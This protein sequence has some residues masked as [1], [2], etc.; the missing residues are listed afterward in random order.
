MQRNQS[1]SDTYLGILRLAGPLILTMSSQMLMQFVDALFL[2]WYSADAV[3]A[4]I[5]AGMAGWLVICAFHGTAMYTSTIVAHYVGAHGFRRVSAALWQGIYFSLATGALVMAVSV[6]SVPLFR[7]VGHE[8]PIRELEATYFAIVCLGAPFTILVGTLSGFFTG[9]GDTRTIF[10]VQ[11]ASAGTN[12]LLDYLLIF[13]KAGLPR[14]GVSGAAVATVAGQALATLVLAALFLS[15]RMRREFETW[16]QR[17]LDRDLL[18]RLVRFGFP[19]G[20]RFAVEM[21]AWTAFLFFIGRI[22]TVE[23]TATNIAW[24]INGFAFFPI[25]GLSQAVGIMV[26]NAQGRRD[27]AL[28]VRITYKGLLMS[29]VW[30]LSAALLFVLFPRELYGLFY[31]PAAMSQAFFA[32]LVR[33]GAFLLRFVALYCLLDAFNIMILGSLQSAGDTRWTLVVSLT[34]HVLFFV[35]LLVA[36]TRKMG[37]YVEWGIATVFVMGQA[38]VWLAR[39]W[40]GRWKTIEVVEREE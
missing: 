11:A 19:N 33:F 22:G 26:G 14:L 38:L 25:I 4:A 8:E 17:R 21:L 3:A 1:D 12:L 20:V 40:S 15:P 36:D 28:S 32:D 9:R 30:M 37:L 7:W 39:F 29:E 16:K 5:P 18:R 27:P 31:N 2:S 24:R 34:A 35:A 10:F 6:V 23:L 13:G